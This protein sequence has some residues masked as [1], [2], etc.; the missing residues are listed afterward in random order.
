MAEIVNLRLARK[1][2]AR[3]EADRKAAERRTTHGLSKSQRNRLI[4][5]RGKLEKSVDQH[6]LEPGDRR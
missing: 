2:V 1:H 6:R 3:L 5:D 4:A